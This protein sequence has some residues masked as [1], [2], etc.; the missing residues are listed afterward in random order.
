ME[1]DSQPKLSF[2]NTFINQDPKNLSEFKEDLKS[3]YNT[4]IISNK[5]TKLS[6][7]LFIDPHYIYRSKD[8]YFVKNVI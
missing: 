7:Q 2:D 5:I 8:N 4:Y 3:A 6:L 1:Q